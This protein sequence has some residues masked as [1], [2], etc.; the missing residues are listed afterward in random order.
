MVGFDP[1]FANDYLRDG[2]EVVVDIRESSW[3]KWRHN[4]VKYLSG[5]RLRAE[6]KRLLQAANAALGP[7]GG[8]ATRA[9]VSLFS[10][11]RIS[12]VGAPSCKFARSRRIAASCLPCCS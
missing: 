10:G 1:R 4:I 5:P 9:R 6:V 8:T 3:G 11:T 7:I 2:A 12:S